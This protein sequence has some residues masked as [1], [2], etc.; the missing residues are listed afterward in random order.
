MKGEKKG[1]EGA[2]SWDHFPNEILTLD[3]LKIVP[4][5][6]SGWTQT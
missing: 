1:K 3:L 6:A 2:V 5:T 4:E